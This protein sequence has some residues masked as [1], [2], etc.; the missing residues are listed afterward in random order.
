MDFKLTKEQELLRKTVREFAENEI[1]PIA[2]EFDESQEFPWD[3]VKKMGRLGLLGLIFPEKY[4][5]SNA[6]YV[7]YAIAVEEV[8]RICGSHGI[9]VVFAKE[10]QAP[11]LP[12]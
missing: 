12:P 4:G 1:K 6:G 3:T 2:A 10:R 8:S 11:D 5:G 7:G 9:T